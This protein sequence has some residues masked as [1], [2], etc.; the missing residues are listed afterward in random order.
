MKEALIRL[1]KVK[2]IIT[3]IVF[4]LLAYGFICNKIK[5]EDFLP[6]LTLVAGFYFAKNGSGE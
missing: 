1:L 3:F 2:T 4:G 5:A 6:I